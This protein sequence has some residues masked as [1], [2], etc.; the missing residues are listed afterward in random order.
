[1]LT[2]M[3]G[4]MIAGGLARA[5]RPEMPVVAAVGAMI[6]GAACLDFLPPLGLLELAAGIYVLVGRRSRAGVIA[7]VPTA[8]I[9]ASA[10]D[11]MV[12]VSGPANPVMVPI[13]VVS[14]VVA[15]ALVGGVVV[16]QRADPR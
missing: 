12:T 3:L 13:A 9:L 1:M 6:L 7:L 14:V 4:W 10:I 15:A 5:K 11:I 2:P 8:M 16:I